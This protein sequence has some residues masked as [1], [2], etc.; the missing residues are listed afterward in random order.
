M[1]PW[2]LVVWGLA[3]VAVLIAN[4][5]LTVVY[6]LAR[7]ASEST[8]PTSDGAPTLDGEKLPPPVAFVRP[9]RGLGSAAAAAHRSLLEQTYAGP[10]EI[11]FASTS[12]KDPGLTFARS[13]YKNNAIVS[14]ISAEERPSTFSNKAANMIAGWHATSAPFVAFCDADIILDPNVIKE[15]MARFDAPDV[16][17]VFAPALHVG[18]D[19]LSQLSTQ[20]S[21]GDKLAVARA[22]DHFGAVNFMEGGLMI[23][24]RNALE[25]AGGIEVLEGALADDLRL[26][27]TLRD[28][29]FTLRAGPTIR[30]DLPRAPG[31]RRLASWAWAQQYHRWMVCQRAENPGLLWPQ[32]AF[33]PIVLPLIACALAARTW[34]AWGLLVGS[35][36]WRVA[37][38]LFADR[39]LM[40]PLGLRFGGWALARPVAD[41]LH[42]AASVSAYLVFTVNWDHRRYRLGRGGQ[43]TAIADPPGALRDRGKEALG[44]SKETLRDSSA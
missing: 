9:L 44:A 23:V 3:L 7:R 6:F 2:S 36:A 37:L 28:Q 24:R 32:I 34:L 38:T 20:I 14:C 43:V 5:F 17:A 12:S 30:H 33:H 22:Y 35:A 40:A 26:A 4:G 41:L 1:T 27:M 11:I 19:L 39:K 29:G 42:F 21:S 10:L 16:G 18:H 13:A 8:S 31:R 25:E 15:C